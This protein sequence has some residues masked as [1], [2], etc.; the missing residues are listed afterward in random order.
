QSD[1]KAP[2]KA[3]WMFGAQVGMDWK[4]EDFRWTLGTAYYTFQGAQ[5]QLSDPCAVYLG[6]NQC[7]T[8]FTRPAFMQKGNTLFLIRNIIPDPSDPAHTRDLQFAGLAFR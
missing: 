8:D 2:T 4:T 3:K 7:S 5:G 6:V 1:S